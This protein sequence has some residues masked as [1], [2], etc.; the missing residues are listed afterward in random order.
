MGIGMYEGAK[1]FVKAPIETTKE[2]VTDIYTGTKDL[3]TKDLDERLM[4]DGVTREE[5]TADQMTK[6]DKKVLMTILMHHH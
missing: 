5:A 1:E 4:P 6:H 3:F 2:V